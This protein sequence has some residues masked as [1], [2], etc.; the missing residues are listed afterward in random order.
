MILAVNNKGGALKPGGRLEVD[1]TVNRQN[2]FSRGVTL[3]LAA[4]AALKLSADPVT[5]AE[6]QTAAKLAIRA[7]ADSPTGVATGVAVR[8]T[9]RV[10]G[11]PI[12]VDEP[13]GIILNK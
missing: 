11:E 6:G 13:V 4:P 1:V 5:V 12:E 7:A 2:G 8:A 3:T 10:N 9:A